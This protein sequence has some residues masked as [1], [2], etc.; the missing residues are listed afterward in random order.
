ML[1]PYLISYNSQVW[2]CNFRYL[3]PSNMLPV[4]AWDVLPEKM[5]GTSQTHMKCLAFCTA[6]R[7]TTPSLKELILPT[8]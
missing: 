7:R 3:E 1:K 6:F 2:P 4:F 8:H 5:A